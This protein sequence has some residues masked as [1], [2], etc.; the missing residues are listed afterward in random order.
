MNISTILIL[1]L[2]G[3]I[4]GFLGGFAGVGGAI[5]I[6]PGLV[7][8]LGMTQFEAQ[9]TSLAMMVPPI[10]ILAAFQYYKNGFVNWKYGLILALAFVLGAYLGSKVVLDIPQNIVKKAFGILLI[11]VAIKLIFSK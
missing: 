9:G 10:G 7:F 2:L 11:F 4:A 8:L 3:L 5:I 1:I 6:I